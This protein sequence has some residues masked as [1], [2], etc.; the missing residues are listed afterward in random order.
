MAHYLLIRSAQSENGSG[1]NPIV[2]VTK[3]VRMK[4]AAIYIPRADGVADS[5]T[6]D[7][8][9]ASTNASCAS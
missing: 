8:M 7:T 4:Y 9:S 2:R 6:V 5:G 1:Q 3:R